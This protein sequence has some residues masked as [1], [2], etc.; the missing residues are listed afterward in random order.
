MTKFLYLVRHAKTKQESID[1]RD[2]SRELANR[3]LRD[4]SLIG[5]YC[6]KQG[7]LID[8]MIS[9]PA[10]RAL[11][12]AELMATQM[13]YEIEKIHTNEELYMTS[14]RTFLQVVNQLK[15]VLKQWQGKE[16]PS[17]E[18][19]WKSYFRDI[20]KIVQATDSEVIAASANSLPKADSK[21][22]AQELLTSNGC[23]GCHAIDKKMLGPSFKDI[24]AKYKQ[25]PQV[26]NMLV[27]S[28]QKGGVGKWGEI[29][30]PPMASLNTEQA[31]LL[32]RFILEQ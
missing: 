1:N 26:Q 5:D 2:F 14:V 27:T 22:Q 15:T 31:K 9:S 7:Y 32:A 29:P 21:P 6:Q 23:M 28:I 30:M 16:Y 4:A 24:A 17:D 8:M 19:R 20:A 11:A 25:E 10:A 18:I 13:D 12:T 3:G